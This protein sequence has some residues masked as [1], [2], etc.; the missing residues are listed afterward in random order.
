MRKVTQLVVL[1][2]LSLVAASVGCSHGKMKLNTSDNKVV[3]GGVVSLSASQIRNRKNKFDVNFVIGNESGKSIIVVLEDL[4]CFKGTEKGSLNNGMHNSGA[5]MVDFRAG[6]SKTF[7]LTCTLAASTEGDP[8]VVV[9]K[10]YDN[11]TDDGV[12]VGKVLTEDAEWSLAGAVKAQAKK[13]DSED[14][15]EADEP[16]KAEPAKTEPAKAEPV[17]TMPAMEPEKSEQ[18]N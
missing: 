1:S 8:R 16:A 10:V 6:E 18:K 9:K 13:A 15:E 11:P 5:T 3:K 4:Q 14:E 17:K 2:V 7:R 12:K